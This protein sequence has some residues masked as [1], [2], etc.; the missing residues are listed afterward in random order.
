MPSFNHGDIVYAPLHAD[1]IDELAAVLL[2]DVVY[3]FIGGPPSANEFKLGLRHALLGPPT[4]KPFER[5][6]N[7]SVRLASTGQLIGRLEATLHHQIA[8]VAYLYSPQFWGQGYATQGLLWLHNHL[9]A[10][11]DIATVRATTVPAN[12]RSAALLRRCGYIQVPAA[13]SPLLYTYDDGDDVFS[14]TNSQYDDLK[15]TH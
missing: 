7:F 13:A 4:S 9:R 15:S 1:D 8:E 12:T 3:E 5:W 6:L 14:Y 2:N 10:Y 11:P